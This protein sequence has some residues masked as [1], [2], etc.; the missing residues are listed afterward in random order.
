MNAFG[1]ILVSLPAY[2]LIN[3]RLARY[4]VLAASAPAVVAGA[5]TAKPD[6]KTIEQETVSGWTIWNEIVK[7]ATGWK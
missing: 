1:W 3:G 2:L 5:D 6:D 7:K 4:L